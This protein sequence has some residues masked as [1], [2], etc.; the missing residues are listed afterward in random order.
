MEGSTLGG[1]LI[2]KTLRGAGWAPEGGLSYFNPYGRQTAAMWS[3][4]R[5]D[6]EAAAPGL[7]ADA[8]VQ[9]AEATF[10]TLRY[11]LANLL[12]AAA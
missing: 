11:G 10:Q 4:F 12:E 2:S 7:D 9:G 3:A 5:T 6:L 8:A 1:Q